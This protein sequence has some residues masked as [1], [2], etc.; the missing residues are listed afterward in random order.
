MADKRR[1]RKTGAKRQTDGKEFS[2][3]IRKK[4]ERKLKAFLDPD[5]AHCGS[6]RR[7]FERMV[8]GEARKPKGRIGASWRFLF[9]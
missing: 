1:E 4:Q 3:T 7:L 6:G 8:L 2:R 9:F 5:P